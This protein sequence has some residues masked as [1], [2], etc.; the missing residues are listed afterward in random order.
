MAKIFCK[1]Y[2]THFN[3]IKIGFELSST[4]LID[5][6]FSVRL[7]NQFDYCQCTVSSELISRTESVKCVSESV[8]LVL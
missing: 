7:S 1:I 5:E 6:G 4:G 2:T 3:Q 8:V